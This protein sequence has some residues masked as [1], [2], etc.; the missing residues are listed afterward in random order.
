MIVK[1]DKKR[2]ETQGGSREASLKEACSKGT[3]VGTR[4]GSEA[5]KRAMSVRVN[6]K[7]KSHQKTFNVEPSGTGRKTMHLTRGD[8]HAL[9]CVQKSAEAIVVKRPCESREE[10]RAEGPRNR[11]ATGLWEAPEWSSGKRG[12]HPRHI[13]AQVAGLPWQHGNVGW[14]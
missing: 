11:L 5:A 13:P 10:Q 7:S 9:A 6:T 12:H 4:S 3:T 14:R 8:L 2:S 1:S